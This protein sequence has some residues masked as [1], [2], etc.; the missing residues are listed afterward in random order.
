MNIK[1]VIT[2]PT[3]NRHLGRLEVNVIKSV[4]SAQGYGETETV[5]TE[6]PVDENGNYQNQTDGI[7]QIIHTHGNVITGI[8]RN[9][10]Q[11]LFYTSAQSVLLSPGDSVILAAEYPNSFVIIP[12]W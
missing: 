3:R 10:E 5:G 1:K 7:L 9:N 11:H 12:L 4:K 8:Y 2:F 6:L